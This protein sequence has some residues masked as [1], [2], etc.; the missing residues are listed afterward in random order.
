MDG[1]HQLYHMLDD[2]FNYVSLA[3]NK[4]ATIIVDEKY[5]KIH[6]IIGDQYRSHI[7]ALVLGSEKSD[8]LS[9]TTKL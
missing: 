5:R 3:I 2:L 8:E 7:S 1:L 6:P 4:I 9:K